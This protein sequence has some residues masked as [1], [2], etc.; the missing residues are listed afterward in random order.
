[1]RTRHSPC[2]YFAS[3]LGAKAWDR[4]KRRYCRL[5]HGIFTYSDSEDAVEPKGCI[6]TS[7][8]ARINIEGSDVQIYDPDIDRTFCLRAPAEDALMWKKAI[9]QSVQETNLTALRQA[10]AL[11]SFTTG[12]WQYSEEFPVDAHSF[13][14]HKWQLENSEACQVRLRRWKNMAAPEA[15]FSDGLEERLEH[16]RTTMSPKSAQ[17]AETE[18]LAFYVAAG[19]ADLAHAHASVQERERRI[20]DLEKGFFQRTVFQPQLWFRG[21][22]TG[23]RERQQAKLDL[24]VDAMELT[25]A[26]IR[27]SKAKLTEVVAEADEDEE[28]MT[29]EELREVFEMFDKNGDGYISVTELRH[30]MAEY[31]TFLN[32]QEAEQIVQKADVDGDG[33]LNFEEFC[34][35]ID[36]EM[37]S[38]ESMLDLLTE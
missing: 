20:K 36:N 23:K 15:A 38:D 17:K 37:G 10:D 5:Q 1:M 21:G 34:A 26:N 11:G 35:V 30:M 33:Q 28:P 29:I 22:I 24:T 25:E 4:W 13:R 19:S 9:E 8:D 12:S 31:G 18:L 32:Q 2:C 7:H 27:A 3:P 6:F 16:I 14:D